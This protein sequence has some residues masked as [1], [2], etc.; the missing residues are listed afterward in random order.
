MHTAYT[1]TYNIVSYKETNSED[2]RRDDPLIP[3][4]GIRESICRIQVAFGFFRQRQN[5]SPL[6]PSSDLN[7]KQERCMINIHCYFTKVPL[8]FPIFIILLPYLL[9]IT[10]SKYKVS[11][12]V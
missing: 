8:R 7:V 6:S 12:L 10:L 9:K 5:F 1:Y 4:K 2:E 11:H 3:Q